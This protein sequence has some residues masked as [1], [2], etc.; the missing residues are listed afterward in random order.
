MGAY[1]NEATAS[2]ANAY[3]R[4]PEKSRNLVTASRHVKEK[5]ELFLPPR[6]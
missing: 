3:H 2:R 5:V 4:L 6:L 1:S